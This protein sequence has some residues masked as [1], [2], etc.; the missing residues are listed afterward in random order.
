MRSCFTGG[1]G[2]NAGVLPKTPGRYCQ[3]CDACFVETGVAQCPAWCSNFTVV[4]MLWLIFCVLDEYNIKQTPT[5]NLVAH[6]PILDA[7]QTKFIFQVNAAGESVATEEQE[8]PAPPGPPE[9]TPVTKST[10]QSGSFTL[11][12]WV[13]KM[14]SQFVFQHKLKVPADWDVSADWQGYDPTDGT[15][16]CWQ[17]SEFGLSYRNRWDQRNFTLV[18]NPLKDLILSRPDE[19]HRAQW[20]AGTTQTSLS[21]FSE[22][23]KPG[24]SQRDDAV[25]EKA[26][27][28]TQ[29]FSRPAKAPHRAS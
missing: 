23:V 20:G 26:T 24:V 13:K 10:D 1:C 5:G 21:W 17:L 11:S 12:V 3:P 19:W 4:V 8:A 7:S 15:L 2:A 29:T 25:P 6:H 27:K 28:A 14:H 9:G 18:E 16:V 22:F